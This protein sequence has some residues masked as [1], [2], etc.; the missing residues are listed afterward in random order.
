MPSRFFAYM[1]T[2]SSLPSGRKSGLP[3]CVVYRVSW[4]CSKPARVPTPRGAAARRGAS[5]VGRAERSATRHRLGGGRAVA[6]ALCSTCGLVSGN[7]RDA[8]LPTQPGRGATYFFTVN[9]P[10]RH[11]GPLVARIDALREAVREVPRQS[12]FRIDAWVELPEHMHCLWRLPESQA[13]NH[14]CVIEIVARHRAAIAG[15]AA[16]GRARHL[17]ARDRGA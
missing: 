5:F 12:P 2:L 13:Q 4:L 14:G 15:Q 8:E 17:A 10:D 16:Q 9:L 1:L 3:T 6:P 11:S 7:F